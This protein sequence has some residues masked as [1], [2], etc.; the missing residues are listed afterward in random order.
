MVRKLHQHHQF[1]LH[2][3]AVIAIALAAV[4][5]IGFAFVFGVLPHAY[6]VVDESQRHKETVADEIPISSLNDI[7]R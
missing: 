2:Q 5:F 1:E 7:F 6:M 4:L 3:K